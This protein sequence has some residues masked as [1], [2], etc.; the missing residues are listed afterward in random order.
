M[1]SILKK[2][3]IIHNGLSNKANKILLLYY[4]L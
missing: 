3:F 1:L 4:Q 2:D